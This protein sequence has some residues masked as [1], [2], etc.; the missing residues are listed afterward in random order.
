MAHLVRLPQLG[1]NVTEGAVGRWHVAEG[2]AVAEGDP[3]VEIIT[4]KAAFDLEAAAAGVVLSIV[5][6]EKSVVPVGFILAITGAPDDSVPDVAGENEL[7]LA[8]FRR[9]VLEDERGAGSPVKIRAT[10]G[11][12]RL[13][14]AEKVDL[15]DV[16]P[17]PGSGVIRAEDVRRFLKF[18]QGP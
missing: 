13:A 10:P 8:Q 18:R 3:L 16:P 4:S 5:A 1:A 11:A 9:A 7:V 6:P 2:D 17:G 12:R 14:R 15:G